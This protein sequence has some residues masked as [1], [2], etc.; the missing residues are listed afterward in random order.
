MHLAFSMSSPNSAAGSLSSNAPPQQADGAFI[1]GIAAYRRHPYVRTLPDPPSIW[2]E[3]GSRLLDYGGSG[4]AVLFVPSLINRA[5]I[6]DLAEERSML[7]HLAAN[8]VRPLLLDWGWP[9]ETERRFTLGDYIAGRL[10]SALAAIGGRWSS[11]ATA[12]AG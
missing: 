5:Y 3:G 9:G 6:L 7:R 2:S 8:G 10:E 12:W 11:P 1:R 4:P